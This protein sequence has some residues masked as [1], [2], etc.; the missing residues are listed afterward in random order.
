MPPHD[1]P[2]AKKGTASASYYNAFTLCYYDFHVLGHNMTYIWRCPTRQHQLPLFQ[3]HFWQQPK[4]DDGQGEKIPMERKGRIW[5][6]LDIGAGT[7]Y[8]VAEALQ[9]CL[10][11][12]DSEAVPR[13][14]MRITLMDI[15][16]SSLSKARKRVEGIL[17]RTD[18]KDLVGVATMH[19]DVLDLNMPRDKGLRGYDVVTMFNLLH[20]LRT[21]TPQDKKKAF[22]FA[23]R[24][25]KDDGALVG[26]TILPGRE[27][28]G[29][30]LAGVRARYTLWLYN[31]VYK[32]FGNEGDT[33]EEFEKGLKAHF[34]E[35]K[36]SVVGSMMLF[37]ARRPKRLGMRT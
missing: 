8:F 24:A 34:Q 7:G 15:N 33:Q 23:A 25:L 21:I 22:Q 1:T 3:A 20:C 11:N 13:N 6:Q 32:V 31:R 14:P 4:H 35:V 17:N 5:E 29:T 10:H 27:Y 12:M 37:V 18:R 36:V 2:Q 16:M 26:C 28:Q 19:H 30:G 9:H